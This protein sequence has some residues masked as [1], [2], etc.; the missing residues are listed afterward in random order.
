MSCDL[1][2]PSS[3]QVPDEL[4]TH[5]FFHRFISPSGYIGIMLNR[6]AQFVGT[7]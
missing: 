6:F 3:R 2:Q 5:Q 4:P 1:V 7:D